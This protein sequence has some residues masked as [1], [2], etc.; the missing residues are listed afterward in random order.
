MMGN[1]TLGMLI[2]WLENQGPMLI[3]KDGFGRPHCDRGD[4]RELSFDP[5]PEA[6]IG[7]MLMH[8]KSALEATF[9]GW[10]GGEFTMHEYTSVMIG[11]DGACGDEIGPVHF[12]YWLLTAHTSV[13]H[14]LQQEATPSPSAEIDDALGVPSTWRR[15]PQQGRKVET[16]VLGDTVYELPKQ[17]ETP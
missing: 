12:K 10:K 8:A 17:E 1:V 6:L 15:P 5:K 16:V 3:V 14:P 9:T 13:S 11:E 2:E 7:D 4:Y